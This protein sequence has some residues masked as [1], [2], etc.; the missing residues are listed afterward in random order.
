[1]SSSLG[2]ASRYKNSVQQMHNAGKTLHNRY[3]L[4]FLLFPV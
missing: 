1:M 3:A 2:I 4:V